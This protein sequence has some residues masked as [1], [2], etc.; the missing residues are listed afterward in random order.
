VRA[1][2]VVSACGALQTPALLARSGFRSP[3]GRLGHNLS[4]HPNT[5]LVAR[6]DRDV[7]GWEGVHQ[8]YQVREFEDEGLVFAAVNVPP[9][10]TAMSIA[11]ISGLRGAALGELM[12]D[13][14]K[15]VIAGM[16]LEDTVTGRVRTIAGRP[17]A[18][19]QISDSDAARMVRGVALLSEMLF[20]AGAKEIHLPFAGAPPAR[21]CEDARALYG[22][23]IRKER[24]ELLTVHMMG[25]AAL[26]SDRSRAVCDGWGV[27]HDAAGLMVADAS[28]FPTPIGVNP[29]E[30][31][32]GLA[33]RAAGHV[34][35]NVKRFV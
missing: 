8:A 28:L 23:G 30:T 19:Y 1:K 27:V 22:A 11:Q 34:I 10:V 3:S 13:Y 18:F 5:K 33:T 20:A 4:L 26:G 7:R 17:Q 35:D 31:I 25:T 9:S 2:L 6:F 15:M 16:L 32:M 24:M 21:S 12:A 29:M 14:D